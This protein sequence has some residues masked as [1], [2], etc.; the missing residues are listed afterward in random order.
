LILLECKPIDKLCDYYESEGFI[1]ITE[2]ADGLKQN[3]R[4][5]E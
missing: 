4:F 5:F 1:D 2:N 3:I